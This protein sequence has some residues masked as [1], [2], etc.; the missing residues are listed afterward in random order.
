MR[1]MRK[2]SVVIAP[3]AVVVALLGGR[4]HPLP[5]ARAQQA[6]PCAQMIVAALPGI[7]DACADMRQ[8]EL[9]Y[10]HPGVSVSLS[11]GETASF[12]APGDVVALSSVESITTG[13]AHPDSGE[14]GAAVL[15]L[16]ADLPAESGQAV[17]AVLYGGATLSRPAVAVSERPTLVVTNPGS[18]EANLRAGAGIT[19]DLVGTLAPGQSAV[20]DGRNEQADWVRIQTG[21][22]VA[23]VFTPL[24]TWEGDLNSLEVLLPNDMTPSVVVGE[25]FQSFVF[26]STGAETVCGV[27]SSGLMLR[28]PASE[29]PARL[30]VNDVTLEFSDA[31]VILYAAPGDVLEVIALS[32]SGKVT[33]R[34]VAV[35]ARAGGGVE[36]SLGGE[37][38]LTPVAAPAAVRS[39]PLAKVINAPVGLSGVEMAC[40]AG[41][42]TNRTDVKLRVG[43]GEQRGEIGNMSPNTHYAVIGWA[44]DP[45]GDPWW[46]LDTGE[47]KS[48]AAQAE[49]AT[50][51]ACEGVAQVE[52]P[53]L[54]FAPP[55]AP[56]AGGEGAVTTVDDLAPEGN[57]VWQMVPGSD[58]MTGQCTGAPAINFC[59]HLAAIAPVSGGI[60]WKGMEASPYYL[61]QL[62]PN[63][64]AYSGPNVLGTGTVN[65]ILRFTSETTLTMTMSLTLTSEPNCQ[66]VYNYTGT[67][68]W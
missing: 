4:F 44:N 43:P 11:A 22:G 30:Q 20:A 2:L 18:K 34:G 8:G 55:P 16:S 6:D 19:Y 38:G 48:W 35:D 51:G 21:T 25:P 27:S 68:N 53:P 60:T 41:L 36:V 17:I 54:V 47:Q 9:C 58:N 65:M 33:A 14:W 23:W 15:L 56:P 49:V 24:I 1:S 28:F 7:Q 29:A 46:Q 45:E 37:D 5:G 31:V 42:A 26:N 50:A 40:M 32:G 39:Y 66:H 61:V 63:V 3:F 57:S 64:Y 52:P 59:D 67:R 13:P 12:A 10:G 62:Q